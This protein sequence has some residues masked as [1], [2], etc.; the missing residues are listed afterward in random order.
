MGDEI[1]I[2]VA[3]SNLIRN[4]INNSEI[5]KHIDVNIYSDDTSNYIEVI[6][7]GCGI[8]SEDINK[9]IEPFYRVDKARSR[10][11]GGAG[12]G[13][14]IVKRVANLHNGELII[15]SEIGVGSKFII[16]I[17]K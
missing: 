8:S 2:S 1:L 6:D 11:Q 14:S 3:L 17:S 13:L 9:I 12:L 10:N 5:N 7:Q 4:A 16:K 15:K